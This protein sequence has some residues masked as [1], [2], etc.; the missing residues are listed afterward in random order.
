MDYRAQ[1]KWLDE[2]EAALTLTEN[3]WRIR[4]DDQDDQEGG[5]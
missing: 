3:P 4:Y 1:K 5:E 2:I